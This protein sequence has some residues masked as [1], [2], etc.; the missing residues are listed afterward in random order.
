MLATA[1][2]TGNGVP[3][4]GA[5]VGT[6]TDTEISGAATG[7]TATVTGVAPEGLLAVMVSPL[8]GLVVAAN[9]GFVPTILALGVTGTLKVVEPLIGTFTPVGVPLVL[10]VVQLTVLPDV[11]H[12]QPLL[13]KLAKAVT[14][15]GNVTDAVKMPLYGAVPMFLTVIGKSLEVPA[16]NVVIG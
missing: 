9:A 15:V 4:T 8:T 10:V 1:I 7:C 3:D 16:V 11:T 6:V 12:D 14:P 13:V 5:E 2:V